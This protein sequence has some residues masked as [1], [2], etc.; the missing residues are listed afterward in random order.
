[1]LCIEI[2]NHS[3]FDVASIG[4][5]AAT[6]TWL[7]IWRIWFKFNS[8]F[9]PSITVHM[10]GP[11]AANAHKMQI[12]FNV[13][14][15]AQEEQCRTFKWP[16]ASKAPSWNPP[17][18]QRSAELPH[19][20]PA[21]GGIDSSQQTN[22]KSKLPKA[23]GAQKPKRKMCT[24]CPKNSAVRLAWHSTMISAVCWSPLK[25]HNQ[26]QLPASDPA[27]SLSSCSCFSSSALRCCRRFRS[28]QETNPQS[29]RESPQLPA[30][31]GN[32]W[33]RKSALCAV[34]GSFFLLAWKASIDDSN[35]S[36]SIFTMDAAESRASWFHALGATPNKVWT[37]DLKL[38]D[39]VW[40]A[41]R[42]LFTHLQSY[43]AM[44]CK[45][46]CLESR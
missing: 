19:Q 38:R 40:P 20:C 7:L 1:M 6:S 13:D 2:I 5:S 34:L 16:K 41:K 43:G 3:V 39:K 14:I 35:A 26:L 46:I 15:K 36:N 23:F 32:C 33:H 18:W 11:R 44:H 4:A 10:L 27:S 42:A 28:W 12:K 24:E 37:S 8:Q 30:K 31:G 9:W 17:G 45:F 22:S 29:P 25:L 21:P